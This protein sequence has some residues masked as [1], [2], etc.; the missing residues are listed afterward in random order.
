MLLDTTV[1]VDVLRRDAT[2]LDRLSRFPGPYIASVIS[3]D[4]LVYGMGQGRADR[5]RTERLIDGLDLLPV[6]LAE[7][8]LA[9]EWRRHHRAQG[10]TLKRPDTLIA[11]TAYLAGLSLA[12]ANVKDFPMPGLTVEH[13]PSG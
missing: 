7:A 4:E 8:R 11:A 13:W 6:G 12:T 9:G 1:L 10:V 3:A 5:D 2:I